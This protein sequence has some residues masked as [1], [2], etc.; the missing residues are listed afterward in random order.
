[1]SDRELQGQRSALFAFLE[2]TNQRELAGLTVDSQGR[3]RIVLETNPVASD[4]CCS[5]S[6]G[7]GPYPVAGGSFGQFTKSELLL[8]T[9]PGPSSTTSGML[10][11]GTFIK[12]ISWEVENMVSGVTINVGTATDPTRFSGPSAFTADTGAKGNS[13]ETGLLTPWVQDADDEIQVTVVSGSF[14]TGTIRFTVV[15][16][17]FN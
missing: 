13:M 1:M 15:F 12:G 11:E 14:T 7:C 17:R 16:E 9:D 2:G 6:S 10:T 4:C 5:S 8:V 3:L